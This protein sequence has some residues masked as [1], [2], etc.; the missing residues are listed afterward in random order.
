MLKEQLQ[1]SLANDQLEFKLESVNNHSLVNKWRVLEESRLFVMQ[2]KEKKAYTT[3]QC[4]I[5]VKGAKHFPLQIAACDNVERLFPTWQYCLRLEEVIPKDFTDYRLVERWM[6]QHIHEITSSSGAGDRP[7]AANRGGS[8][9][10]DVFDD[11]DDDDDDEYRQYLDES[12][13][14]DASASSMAR[15]DDDGGGGLGGTSPPRTGLRGLIQSFTILAKRPKTK[16][17]W[18]QRENVIRQARR[19]RT[20]A[21]MIFF[22]VYTMLMRVMNFDGY[23]LLL[24]LLEIFLFYVSTYYREIAIRM[25]KRGAEN[26]V[27]RVKD[28]FYFGL[29][30]HDERQGRDRET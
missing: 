29:T 2:G 23:L 15:K 17:E 13:R 9:D 24:V 26:R 5:I 8:P 16:E 1:S 22:A 21:I 28:W 12:Q 20:A 7:L 14:N 19:N 4:R 6:K 27:N 25:A 10:G 11:D 30:R 18:R 3:A